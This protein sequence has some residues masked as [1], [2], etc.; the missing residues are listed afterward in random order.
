LIHPVVREKINRLPLGCCLQFSFADL[1]AKMATRI[2]LSFLKL[3][4]ISSNKFIRDMKID[5]IDN[6]ETFQAI[7]SNWDLV[8]EADPQAQFFL[9]WI[10]LREKLKFY[11]ECNESWFILAA[12]SSSDAT[13]YVAFFPLGI[14][15][16]E[17][18]DG[19]GFYNKLFMA[20]GTDSEHIGFICRSEYEEE[21]S[22]AFAIYLQQQEE[23]S[24]LEMDKIPETHKRLS[25]FLKSLSLESIQIE[26]T[27]YINDLDTIDNGSV[28]YILLPDDWE[29]YLQNVISSNTRQKIR[30]LLRKIESS[31]EFHVTHVNED[32]LEDHLKILLR[33]WKTSWEDRKGRER[34]RKIIAQLYS[35]LRHCF[36][37]N[38]LYLPVLWQG[39]KPIGAI[40]NL[41]DFKKK[42]ILFFVGGR[43]ETI[44][45][46]PPGIVL[47]AYGIQYAIQ[48]GFKVYDFLM[49]NEAYKFSFGAKERRIKNI[50]VR[51]KRLSN[52]NRKLDVRTIPKAIKITAN[53]HQANRLVE[54]EQGYSQIMEVQPEHPDALYG[55]SVIMQRKGE[56][57]AA[58]NLLKSLVQVQPNHTKAW[59]SLGVLHQ[60]QGQLSEAEKAYQQALNLQPQSSAISLAIYHNLGYSLQ[61]QGKWSEAIACY[62]KAR[63]LQPD[64]IEAEVGL[65]NAFHAQGK[66]SSQEQARYAALNFD[67]GNKRRQAGDLKVAVEYYQQALAMN[68][69]LVDAHYNL[70]LAWQ[71]QS[72]WSEAIACYQKARELQPDSIEVEVALG[73]AFH[74]QGKLSSEEQARYAALNFDLGNKHRQA[75]DLK[76]A[77]A[78]YRQAITMNPDL[79]DARDHLRLTLQEQDNIKIKVSCAKR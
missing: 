55:L 69:D 8:Y 7:K 9:S 75:G 13:D 3:S 50:K 52:P 10:W 48:N 76:V 22:S 34:C 24:I 73:N 79:V 54:A 44:R 35:N 57:Q 12:K 49:G 31:N 38:C 59:F 27:R 77:V 62:Q 21:V 67:L 36:E 5:V 15:V 39:D 68:P 20:G 40:A 70:G 37:H 65:G 26:E 28:P 43:D 71:K 29:Q 19:G 14:L 58:E 64:S 60:I 32:N 30:R 74:A 11:E 66:L 46:L 72:K 6:F 41:I 51:R 33:F 63:E 47:H 61:Q 4:I 16:T 17:Y 78:Y 53:H 2:T 18:K 25:L 1:S 56:C 23:W 45:D 42:S